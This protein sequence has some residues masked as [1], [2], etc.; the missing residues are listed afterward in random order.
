MC[1]LEMVIAEKPVC[2]RACLL[3][4]I[5]KASRAC[6]SEYVEQCVP[7]AEHTHMQKSS[8]VPAL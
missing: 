5:F 7:D 6:M 1:M 8:A 2:V 4:R 3:V